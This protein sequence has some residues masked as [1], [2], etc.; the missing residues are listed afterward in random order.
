VERRGIGGCGG[1]DYSEKEGRGGAESSP[2]RR[3]GRGRK[4]GA[5]EL[6]WLLRGEGG[7][8]RLWRRE[9]KGKRNA[10]R[11]LLYDR[12][13]REEEKGRFFGLEMKTGFSQGKDNDGRFL[14]KG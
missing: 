8:L 1:D 13:V 6:P 3:R 12:K 4:K 7:R 14:R 5:R 9:R 2:S 11:M 10:W